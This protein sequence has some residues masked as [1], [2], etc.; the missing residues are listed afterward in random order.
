MMFMDGL[1]GM[2]GSA[3]YMPPGTLPPAATAGLELP[4]PPGPLTPVG[5]TALAPTR[6]KSFM[7][8]VSTVSGMTD[9]AAGDECPFEVEQIPRGGGSVWCRTELRCGERVLYGGPGQGYFDCTFPETEYDHLQAYDYTMA[10]EDGDPSFTIDYDGN[11]VVRDFVDGVS[12]EVSGRI[13]EA[14]PPIVPAPVPV[15]EGTP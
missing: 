14:P 7:L 12:R 11:L 8:V 6:Q 9:V 2:G 15:L 13:H 3:P 4:P 5:A 1:S 10:S